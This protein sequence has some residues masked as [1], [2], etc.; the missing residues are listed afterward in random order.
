M[1]TTNTTRT[2]RQP[3]Q[4]A[5]VRNIRDATLLAS[6]RVKWKKIFKDTGNSPTGGSFRKYHF[7]H[8]S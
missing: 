3:Q 1:Q 5:E 7:L 2:G 8:V 6:D 4:A